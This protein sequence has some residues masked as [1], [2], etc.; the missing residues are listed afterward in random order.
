MVNILPAAPHGTT[1]QMSP[2][3]Q[4]LA[5]IVGVVAPRRI[6]KTGDVVEPGGDQLA[7]LEQ[8]A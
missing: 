2:A 7:A 1:D 6:L 5:V 4:S 8:Y 3:R